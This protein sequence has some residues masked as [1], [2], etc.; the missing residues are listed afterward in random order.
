MLFK[1]ITGY[2]AKRRSATRWFS[3]NDVQELS[4]FPNMMNGKLL[5]WVD[6]M[7]EHGICD[8]TAPKLRI[9]LL[10]PTKLR[11]FQDMLPRTIAIAL[12]TAAELAH[13]M[14]AAAALAPSH[15]AANHMH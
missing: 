11:H 5:A 12:L 14:L 10:N 1:E 8:K 2:A 15:A 4:L 6:K 7:V 9:F 3:T 13:W